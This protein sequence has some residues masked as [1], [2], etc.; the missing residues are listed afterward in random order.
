MLLT[1]EPCRAALGPG[2]SRD[3]YVT[4][5]SRVQPLGLH[6]LSTDTKHPPATK[7]KPKSDT[8]LETSERAARCILGDDGGV[9]HHQHHDHHVHAEAA[10]TAPA[11][12]SNSLAAAGAA[13]R[14]GTARRIW[15]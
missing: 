13:M 15:P 11:G 10:A 1:G 8:T 4:K 5:D 12:A 3:G 6:S 14:H 9:H 2:P 7:E